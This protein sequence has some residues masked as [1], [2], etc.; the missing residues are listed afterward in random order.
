MV[1]KNNNMKS[2]GEQKAEQVVNSFKQGIGSFELMKSFGYSDE[3]IKAGIILNDETP[4][5]L[6]KG[7]L[8]TSHLVL[9]DVTVNGKVQKR[10]VNPNKNDAEHAQH[11]SEI[12]FSHKGKDMKGKVGSITKTGE[13]AV[14]GEDGKTYNKH[15]H[16]FSSPHEEKLNEHAS[17]TD[18]KKLQN[19]VSNEKSDPKLKEIAQKELDSRNDNKNDQKT[20]SKDKSDKGKKVDEKE[21]E[22]LDEEA[23]EEQDINAK[24]KTYEKFVR[25]TAKGLSKSTIAYG[26]GGVGK[27]Y[28]AMKQLQSMNNPKTGKP[29][30][31]FDEDNHE[32]G[33]DDYDAIK[34]TG[35]ATTAGL[36]KTLYQHNNKLILFDDCDEVLKDPNSI[37]MFKG[38]LDSSGDGTISNISGAA[39]KGDDGKPIPQRYKFAGRAIFISNLSAKQLPQPLKSRSLR[40]DLS[41]DADQTIQRI[42]QIST[43]KD[44][45]MTNIELEDTDGEKVKYSHED[46]EVAIKFMEK[47]KNKMSDINVRTLG[48]I[49]KLIHDSK[50]DEDDDWETAAKHF[51]FSKSFI[52]SKADLS[53]AFEFL[54]SK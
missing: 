14:R 2:I 36:Y 4:D 18:T 9:K 38:A 54:T 48:S 26:G 20:D 3:E 42:K 47:H 31:F 37:N 33:S 32:A 28:T 27:T 39:I 15:A 41:M 52:P 46:M 50:D 44:G 1:F 23:D 53:K 45:K 11:G 7:K 6:I 34:I 24:F 51:V 29:F 8:D 13:Y 49:V 12:S 22:N 30:V 19:F 21:I 5:G 16:Q 35:K 40:V 17:G 43:G 10:W 25:M